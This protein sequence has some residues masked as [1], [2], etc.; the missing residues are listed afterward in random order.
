MYQ[1]KFVIILFFFCLSCAAEKTDADW[2]KKMAE[3]MVKNQLEKRGI[4]D[5]GDLRAMR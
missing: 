3:I 4:Q 5:K 1:I 2:W